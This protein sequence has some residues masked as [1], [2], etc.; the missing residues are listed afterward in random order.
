MIRYNTNNSFSCAGNNFN[1]SESKILFIRCSWY[2]S[3]ELWCCLKSLKISELNWKKPLGNEVKCFQKVQVSSSY[4]DTIYV[5]NHLLKTVRV[6][7]SMQTYFFGQLLWFVS[8]LLVL[9]WPNVSGVLKDLQMAFAHVIPKTWWFFF[10]WLLIK[11][12]GLWSAKKTHVP[13]NSESD[14]IYPFRFL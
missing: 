8:F 3:K 2:L 7:T 9:A 6:N 13:T 12:S 5:D 1:I 10:I 4:T 14:F 11:V